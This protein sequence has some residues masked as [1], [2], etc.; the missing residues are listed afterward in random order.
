[1]NHIDKIMKHVPKDNMYFDIWNET[2]NMNVVHKLYCELLTT[3]KPIAYQ[4]LAIQLGFAA[5]LEDTPAEAFEY[6]SKC[7]LNLREIG[8]FEIRKARGL[9][10]KS[11]YKLEDSVL[12]EINAPDYTWYTPKQ[13]RQGD[14]VILG[15]GN[16]HHRK[17][18]IDVLNT[19]QNIKFTLDY[20]ILTQ[21]EDNELFNTDH[22]Q[23]VSAGLLGGPFQ[24]E[25][26]YDKRGR[27]Y[28]TGYDI[29]L[30]GNE[31]KKALISLH[32]KE[33]VTHGNV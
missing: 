6:G 15:R 5:G 4:S 33:V 18:A 32:N 16:N 7:L 12:A 9:S 24:F 21:F 28:S 26:K 10:I 31:Y 20:D 11:C 1:M 3:R 25:W 29:Q 30:Q 8:L 14:E 27:S 17:Q 2:Q 13:K 22:F 19:L 23:A